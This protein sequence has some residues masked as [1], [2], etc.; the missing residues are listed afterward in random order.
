[1][2]FIPKKDQLIEQKNIFFFKKRRKNEKWKKI[3]NISKSLIKREDSMK[4]AIWV[5]W[6]LKEVEQLRKRFEI[7]FW[8]R[9]MLDS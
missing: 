1:M 9:A 7:I 2:K 3:T 8:E 5:T 6:L 4:E